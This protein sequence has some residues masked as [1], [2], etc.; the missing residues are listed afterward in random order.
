MTF[1]TVIF[2]ICFFLLIFS[3]KDV[4]KFRVGFS[5]W[6]RSAEITDVTRRDVDTFDS[7]DAKTPPLV[8]LKIRPSKN[9][10][11]ETWS[12]PPLWEIWLRLQSTPTM[13]SP[14][15]LWIFHNS[16]LFNQSRILLFWPIFDSITNF[17]M[18]TCLFYGMLEMSLTFFDSYVKL[19][20]S[21]E[22]SIR[23]LFQNWSVTY[24]FSCTSSSTTACLR[25]SITVTC[26][27]DPAKPEKSEFLHQNSDVPL[28]S[29][30]RELPVPPLN[31]LYVK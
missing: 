19:N 10:W 18:E 5:K 11:S 8:S 13:P 31:K 6:P 23:S 4:D 29:P 27:T 24:A 3:S 22:S 25:L 17:P 30:T 7:C 2:H 16:S 15:Y 9:T 12:M 20:W 1:Q 26:V 28:P 14:R 21:M